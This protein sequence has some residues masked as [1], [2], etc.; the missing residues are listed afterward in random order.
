MRS[1]E[2][3]RRQ[4]FRRFRQQG[5]EAGVFGFLSQ[6]QTVIRL[7]ANPKINR[8]TYRLIA[9]ATH[10]LAHRL[11]SSFIS[12]LGCI[13]LLLECCGAAKIPNSELR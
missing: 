5:F 13:D 7:S 6:A 4:R 1:S 8:L 10:N 3:E 9:M 12:S 2:R 11:I